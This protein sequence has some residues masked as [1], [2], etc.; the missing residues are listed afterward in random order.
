[1]GCV[2]RNAQQ[3][4]SA[5]AH[6]TS[7]DYVIPDEN[8][9]QP[10]QQPQ[11]DVIQLNHTQHAAPDAAA[12]AADQYDT[13]NPQTLGQQPQYDFISRPPQTDEDAAAEYVY[14]N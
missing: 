7:D 8:Q 14:V 1:M 2:D 6:A 11:Y 9:R 13:L 10:Q 4:S 12:A 5:K 3:L